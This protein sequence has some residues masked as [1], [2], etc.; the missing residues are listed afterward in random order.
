MK[1]AVLGDL[2]EDIF[3]YG[4]CNRLNP[5]GP[6]PL[7]THNRTVKRL[8]GAGNVVEN[9]KSLGLKTNFYCPN[10]TPSRKTRINANGQIICR[11]DEDVISPNIKI[12][13]SNFD[14]DYVILSDYNKGALDD[15]CELI[16]QINCNVFVDPKKEFKNYRG[17]Y[18]IKPNKL[19]FEKFWG[20]VTEE[21]LRSLAEQNHHKLVIVTLGKDGVIYYYDGK[22]RTIDS[23]ANQV[24]DV[25]GAGDCFMAAMIYGLVRGMS[26]HEAIEMGNLGAGISVT[27]PGTYILSKNDLIK[28]KVFTNGCFDILHRGH[29]NLLEASKKMGDYLIVGVNSDA[30]VKRLKGAE[31]PINNQEDR[32][33]ALESLKFVDEVIVFDEDTPY[34]LIKNVKPDII[35][36]GGDYTVESVVGNDL[37]IVKIIPLVEGYS[38]TKIIGEL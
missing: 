38:T 10:T 15:C 14:Y 12:D 24:A 13:Y 28:T 7:V 20:A 22:V 37:A 25:T 4:S 23:K 9:L 2:I 6:V 30:S 34:E 33:K 21:N 36:K 1:I 19:E 11:L 29:I 27:H 26:V 31:R 3:I 32:K 8:G 16:E 17:A 35:T 5:E 18:C